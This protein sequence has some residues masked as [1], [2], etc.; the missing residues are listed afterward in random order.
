ML[1][2]VTGDPQ[3]NDRPTICLFG[4]WK[5]SERVKFWAERGENLRGDYSSH[6]LSLNPFIE[7]EITYYTLDTL[8]KKYMVSQ[9]YWLQTPANS[10][11]KCAITLGLTASVERV[12]N[13]YKQPFNYMRVGFK[14]LHSRDYVIH[15]WMVG[16]LFFNGGPNLWC[17][18]RFQL[19]PIEIWKAV[20]KGLIFCVATQKIQCI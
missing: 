4:Q 16:P 13:T 14:G 12:A 7:K 15:G 8:G 3:V 5:L 18:W 1:P 10:M 19:S 11:E 17:P 9:K 6:S 20:S 2:K